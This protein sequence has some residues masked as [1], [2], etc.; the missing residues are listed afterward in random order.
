M[1]INISSVLFEILN[2][3][4]ELVDE[5]QWDEYQ[6]EVGKRMIFRQQPSWQPQ[7]DELH[8]RKLLELLQDMEG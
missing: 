4:A 6:M 5:Y 8:H 1:P 7:S 3:K 2:I